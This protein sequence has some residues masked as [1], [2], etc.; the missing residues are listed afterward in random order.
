MTAEK[1]PHRGFSSGPRS[2]PAV[3]SVGRSA[4]AGGPPH[5][6]GPPYISSVFSNSAPHQGLFVPNYSLASVSAQPPG[7][8]LPQASRPVTMT[9]ITT[10]DFFLLR[11]SESS[12]EVLGK[13]SNLLQ[14]SW[15]SEL[16]PQEDHLALHP[17]CQWL[18]S[19]PGVHLSTDRETESVVDR[20][21]WPELTQPADGSPFP[22]KNIR[23][24]RADGSLI[25]VGL[26]MFL[27]RGSGLDFRCVRDQ[28]S[29]IA[30]WVSDLCF[31]L[32]SL[33][34]H[35]ETFSKAYIVVS[36][37]V[38]DPSPV[39][40]TPTFQSSTPILRPRSATDAE[41]GDRPLRNQ[42]S[43]PN[44]LR[45]SFAV[46]SSSVPTRPS[47][48]Q[49]DMPSLPSITSLTNEVDLAHQSR[50][51]S[52]S[53]ETSGAP[54]FLNPFAPSQ[55]LLPPTQSQSQTFRFQPRPQPADTS[56]RPRGI[57]LPPPTMV[58]Y[59]S[60]SARLNSPSI[61]GHH[62]PM[63]T[64]SISSQPQGK[65]LQLPG[66][67]SFAA[68]GSVTSI[69][70]GFSGAPSEALWSPS[71]VDEPWRRRGSALRMGT[72]DSTSGAMDG[73]GLEPLEPP[74]FPFPGPHSHLSPDLR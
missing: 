21:T 29:N 53:G 49:H 57:V 37:T 51:G 48:R 62:R 63:S 30:C 26:R 39:S 40:T 15:I 59:G 13:Q 70:S 32:V 55:T 23:M 20:S 71:L 3:S 38:R 73:L 9:L 64:E 28:E 46:P 33:P 41:R 12:A 67:S 27:G 19:P 31:L 43:F 56:H 16:L 58:G 10:T 34:R 47:G 44:D 61:Y 45:H 2:A 1:S 7:S 11:A 68:R 50:R 8:S 24:I 52:L 17:L 72:G 54:T 36:C 60:H 4:A 66:F 35:P 25:P 5:L 18:I 6:H 14:R 65:D 69:E 22:E 74:S 42:S